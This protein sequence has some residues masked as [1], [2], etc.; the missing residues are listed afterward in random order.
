[1]LPAIDQYALYRILDANYNRASEGLRTLEEIARFRAN[2]SQ[3]QLQLKSLRHQLASALQFLP[4]EEL[5]KSRSATGDV[6]PENS[7]R[8]ELERTS[9]EEIQTAAAH[10]IQQA[11]RALEEFSKPLHPQAAS[12]FAK[13][14]YSAYDLLSKALLHLASH[15]I[16]FEKAQ[17][18]L[19]VD[20]KLDAAAWLEHLQKLVDAGADIIQIRDKQADGSILL[21]RCQQAVE[22]TSPTPVRI[23]VNDRPDIALM[24][25]AD[26]VHLGQED[27]PVAAVRNWVGQRL[28]I[29]LST[30]NAQQVSTAEKSSADYIGC[31]PTFPST[32]KQFDRFSGLEFLHQA[33][34]TSLPAFAIGGITLERLPKVLET[35]FRRV[36]IAGDV[37]QAS[38]PYQR[39]REYRKYLDSY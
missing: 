10:R 2:A 12:A 24:S 4:V 35:G 19:L 32:T 18:Y 22:L 38:D 37:H 28:S 34:A 29:G 39:V 3:L 23:I 6:G 31:G 27:L 5:L 15:K 8:S 9:L 20:L 26:G 14:R 36:A 21:E 7:L 13:I 33:A 11:L 17:I 25:G 1:M 30:H 16:P